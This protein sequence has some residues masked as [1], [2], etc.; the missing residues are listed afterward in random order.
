MALWEDDDTR[1]FYEALPDL[2][3]LVPAILLGGS[4]EEENTA[5]AAPASDEGVSILDAM[6]AKAREK[7]AKETKERA[8]KEVGHLHNRNRHTL[9]CDLAK[10]YVFGVESRFR[11]FR[12]ARERFHQ[13]RLSPGRAQLE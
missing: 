7:E 8:E 4:K 9:P 2:R 3:A 1:T 13:V 6:D 10:T 11:R 5:S 12:R